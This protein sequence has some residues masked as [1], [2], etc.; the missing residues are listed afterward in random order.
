MT[1]ADVLLDVRGLTVR[2]GARTVIEDVSFVVGRSD[3][4]AVV[5][6]NGAGKSTLFAGL[7]GLL[8]R[9]AGDVKL[10]GSFAYV[11]QGGP[12]HSSFPVT[13]ED[14]ALMG[15]YARTPLL[16]RLA[17]SDRTRARD[18]LARV[19]LGDE[20]S[21][22]YTELSGGQRQRVLLA[23]ALVQGGSVLLLDEP[24]SGV[25]AVSETAIVTA[26][27]EER[28]EGRAVVI[29][30]HDLSFARTAATS[31]LLLNRR[32]HA[33]GPPERALTAETL[34]AAYGGRLIV[35]GDGSLHGLDEGSHGCG[36]GHEH[37]AAPRPVTASGR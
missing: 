18:A 19:G 3:L 11:P 6:P 27:D 9:V 26:L 4:V 32:L 25:D 13:A 8:P 30:T 1:S 5:G 24:L 16:R 31:A 17:R 20:S 2:R 22:P 15:A 21:S 29:A 34:A 7:L 23:R 10:R 37:D 35:L 14:V 36:P 28:A 33:A 12:S